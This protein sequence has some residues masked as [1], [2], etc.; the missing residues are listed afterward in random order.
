[1]PPL[2]ARR[3]HRTDDDRFLEFVVASGTGS[4]DI[5][6]RWEAGEIQRPAGQRL[7]H[8]R[9]SLIATVMGWRPDRHPHE[10]GADSS[11]HWAWLTVPNC[12][13]PSG[14]GALPS[15]RR[16]RALRLAQTAGSAIPFA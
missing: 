11:A 12:R 16:L 13:R 14:R 5:H 8:D 6:G 10:P 3:A 9:S 15:A 2:R 7:L 1:V 4:A